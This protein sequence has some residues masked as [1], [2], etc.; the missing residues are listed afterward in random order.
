MTANQ[1][2]QVKKDHSLSSVE[3]ETGHL[4]CLNSFLC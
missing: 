3:V 2:D 4:K 1:T